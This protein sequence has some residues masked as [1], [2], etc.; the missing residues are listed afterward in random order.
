MS[1]P[2]S[3]FTEIFDFLICILAYLSDLLSDHD[4]LFPVDS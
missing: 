4:F 3:H 1:I 2:T